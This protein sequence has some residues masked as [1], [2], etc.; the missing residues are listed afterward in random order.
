MGHYIGIY[1]MFGDKLISKRVQT[2]YLP[3]F[4]INSCVCLTHLQNDYKFCKKRKCNL[5][6]IWF[7]NDDCSG[8]TGT[9]IEKTS[10]RALNVLSLI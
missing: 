3:Y 8:L 5:K 9:E 10:E 6:H 2:T 1:K 4:S 7:V